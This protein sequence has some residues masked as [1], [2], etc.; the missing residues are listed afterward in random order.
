MECEGGRGEKS[1]VTTSG[2]SGSGPA[3]VYARIPSRFG[4]EILGFVGNGT[5]H[6]YLPLPFSRA[7][8]LLKI[9]GR[10]KFSI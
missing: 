2:E 8:H 4:A 1:V 9:Q 3:L 7:N 5:V 10:T 6:A